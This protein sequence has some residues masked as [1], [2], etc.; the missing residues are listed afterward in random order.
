[1]RS[2]KRLIFFGFC[3]DQVSFL[4]ICSR[5]SLVLSFDGDYNWCHFHVLTSKVIHFC[6][7]EIKCQSVYFEFYLLLCLL[8]DCGF[9]SQ[10]RSRVNSISKNEMD[11]RISLVMSDV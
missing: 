4:Y 6:V 7:M 3:I 8:S 10:S 9:Y 11:I 5:L 2:N 1:M